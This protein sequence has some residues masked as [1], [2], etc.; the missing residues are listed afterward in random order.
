MS[1]NVHPEREKRQQEQKRR[2][3]LTA[4]FAGLGTGLVLAL[5]TGLWLESWPFA[6]GLGVVVA[7]AVTFGLNAIR[8]DSREIVDDVPEPDA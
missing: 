2:N 4:L 3:Q 1:T 8:K 6:V 7:L 5:L